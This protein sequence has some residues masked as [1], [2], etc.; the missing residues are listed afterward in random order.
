MGAPNF[1]FTIK[2]VVHFLYGMLTL[3]VGEMT[4]A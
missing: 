3:L 2:R 4:Y 1:L